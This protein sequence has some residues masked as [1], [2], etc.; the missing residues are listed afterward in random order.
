MTM[1]TFSREAAAMTTTTERAFTQSETACILQLKLGSVRAWPVFLD[2]CKQD[3]GSHPNGILR[4]LMLKPCGYD[5]A[6]EARRPLYAGRDIG[7][8]IAD[9]IRL[10]PDA[11][12]VPTMGR[13]VSIDRDDGKPWQS[14]RLA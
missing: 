14:R 12:T 6:I 1:T 8:F 11:R 9:V 10:V 13:W 2:Q 4:G 3:R 5:D 7:Q